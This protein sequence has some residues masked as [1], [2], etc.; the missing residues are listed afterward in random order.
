MKD[1][2]LKEDLLGGVPLRPKVLGQPAV[3]RVVRGEARPAHEDV[4]AEYKHVSALK[5][6]AEAVR[7]RGVWQLGGGQSHVRG[8]GGQCPLA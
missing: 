8:C 3:A 4:L 5:E 1:V 2:R 7:S 6:R